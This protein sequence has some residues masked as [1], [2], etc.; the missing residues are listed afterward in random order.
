MRRFIL[1]TLLF[2]VSFTASAGE[3]EALYGTW[4][5]AKQC[6]RE[7]IKEGGTVLSEPFVISDQWMRHGQLWCKLSW[8]PIDQR[9]NGIFTGARAQCGEDSVR[10][11][12]I[13]ME[14][15]GDELTIR[16]DFPYKNGPLLQCPSS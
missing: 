12:S 8:F 13:G 5:T 7:P 1:T 2:L 14:L 10:S 9:K 16:W 4:G 3:R 6:A 15:D 11:Y